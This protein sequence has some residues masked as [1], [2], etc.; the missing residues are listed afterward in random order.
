[1]QLRDS[2]TILKETATDWNEDEAPRLA[3]S[4]AYYTIM[5][6]APLVVIA[7]SVIGLIFDEDAARGHIASQLVGIVGEQAAKAIQGIV[8]NARTP[9]AGIVSST[10]GIGVLLA[11]ASGVFGEL[12]SSLNTIWDVAPKPGRGIWGLVKARFLSFTMVL[13]VAFMLLVSLLLSAA[14]AATGHFLESVLPGGE[15]TWQIVTS[16]ISLGMVTLLFALIFKVIPDVRIEWRDVWVGA[17]GTA[18][19]FT[20][21]KLLLGL[22]L[23]KSTVSS[24]YGAAGSLVVLVLWVNYSAQILFFGA[25]FTQVHARHRGRELRP[26]KDAVPLERQEPRADAVPPASTARG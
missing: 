14:L 23:G 8:Q 5:S 3:A 17:I 13:G 26:T 21:G 9:S 22:Y 1:M 25:E 18:L 7:M 6:L 15:A 12:Q 11:G 10:I 4:L 2:W 16:V 19:L 24:S 20:M